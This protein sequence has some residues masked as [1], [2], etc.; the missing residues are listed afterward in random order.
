MLDGG[1]GGG[2]GGAWQVVNY[3]IHLESNKDLTTAAVTMLGARPRE[4]GRRERERRRGKER[5]RGRPRGLPCGMRGASGQSTR[6]AWQPEARDG[7]RH[8]GRVP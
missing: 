7:A 2:G 3:V 5:P 1:G 8:S 6:G 4:S